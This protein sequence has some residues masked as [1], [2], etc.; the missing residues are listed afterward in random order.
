MALLAVLQQL[1]LSG[2]TVPAGLDATILGGAILLGLLCTFAGPRT[3]QRWF[4][5]AEQAMLI[6]AWLASAA[7]VAKSG[8]P[9]SP[10]IVLFAAGVL[11]CA[12]FL[13]SGVAAAQILLGSIAIWAPI[14]YDTG[15]AI[16]SGFIVRAVA[17]TAAMWSVAV[18][19][20]RNR[21][22]LRRAEMNARRMALTDPL[23]GVANLRTFDG[24]FAEQ[25]MSAYEGE[26]TFGVAFID[27]NGL[28][29]AN[30]VH[31]HSGG[32]RMI[33]GT[34][35]VLMR[36]ASA[37]DQVARL[38][39]DEFAVL[40]PGA[41]RDDVLGFEA[42]FARG[43]ND[44]N[45]SA[46]YFGPS[47]SA[48]VGSAVFPRDGEDL[49]SLMRVADARMNSSKSTLPQ[50][51]PVERTSGGR[52]LT[53]DAELIEEAREYSLTRVAGPIAGWA[54][55]MGGVVILMS[56]LFDSSMGRHYMLSI[57]LAAVCVAVALAIQLSPPERRGAVVRVGDAIAVPMVPAV[58]YATGGVMSIALPLIFLVVAHTSY[59]LPV[60]TAIWRTTMLL[61]L[62]A[63]PLILGASLARFMP[64]ALILAFTAVIAMLLQWNRAQL[65]A[66][67]TQ[68]IELAN[69][70]A[71]TGIANRRAF[72]AQLSHDGAR[73]RAGATGGGL[74]LI[75]IDD[76]N[77]TN[78]ASGHK[79]G[80]E[81]LKHLSAVLEGA[82]ARIGRVCRIGGDEFAL[83]VSEGGDSDVSSAAALSRAAVQSVDWSGLH[84]PGLTVSVGYATWST[85]D[86]WAELVVA[87]DL[88]LRLSKQLGKDRISASGGLQDL[89]V[90]RFAR[91][92]AKSA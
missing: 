62:L 34:A 49:D 91:R 56:A 68:A 90:K 29:A 48:S 38:G 46:E 24:E 23:T 41:D 87:A 78:T 15:T 22:A 54:W 88:A 52:R 51:L 17:F 77:A 63:T 80:D 12:F 83:V 27:I 69:T 89:V 86:D 76:F 60:G 82:T 31:G 30:T 5:P 8:G 18:L 7:L 14:A 3:P 10:L 43:L 25:L 20:S 36:S 57:A 71:L 45:E 50:M 53:P 33:C 13:S 59:S 16:D 44:L 28:K 79:G 65:E 85:V 40:M 61:G 72:E 1:G 73:H 84:P 21:A 81:I 37:Q 11:Y 47:V 9:E 74:V 92:H 58:I 55:A 70:D 42:R 39:G 6:L 19:V 67:R 2:F 64:V 32:D 4:V 66:A 35:E 26:G 75:D